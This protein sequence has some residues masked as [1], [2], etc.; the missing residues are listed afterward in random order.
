VA[1]R[2][3][4]LIT[5]VLVTAAGAD[6]QSGGDAFVS[7]SDAPDPV[8]AGGEITLTVTVGSGPGTATN[9]QLQSA[10]PAQTTPVAA[11]TGQPG[12]S[13]EAVTPSTTVF[14]C[15]LGTIAAATTKT[16]TLVVRTATTAT[17]TVTSETTITAQADPNP[18]N[19]TAKTVT[20]V[21]SSS[22]PP[23]P[24]PEPPLEEIPEE[25]PEDNVSPPPPTLAALDEDPPRQVSDVRA[26]VGNRSVAMR[27]RPPPDSD[28]AQVVITRSTADT[29][30]R[31]VYKGNKSDFTDRGLRNGTLYMY[32][33]RTVDRSGNTSDGV[34]VAATPR[35]AALFA[36]QANARL[37][38]PPLLRW[39]AVPGASYYNV[40]LYRGSRKILSA[41]PRSTQLLLRAQWRFAGRRERL[42]P[43]AYHWFVWPGRGPRSR[44]SYGPLIGRSSFVIVPPA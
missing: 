17:G 6:A 25:I 18:S 32:E 34:W 23:P 4:I 37:S 19:N 8:A 2:A 1:R 20:T 38:K 24:P 16:A 41:W 39:V 21:T 3:L 10:V 44:S 26:R 7:M 11:A 43:G 29:A 33:L 12:T 15:T 36:P 28:F 9:V 42:L 30:D 27:W 5:A 14:K 22:P 40:Q 35:G 13:C 31:V